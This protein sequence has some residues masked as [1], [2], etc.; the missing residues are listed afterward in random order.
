MRFLFVLLLFLTQFSFAQNTGTIDSTLL[1][2]AAWHKTQAVY[3]VFAEEDIPSRYDSIIYH[4][5]K[6]LILDT[7]VYGANHEEVAKTYFNMG[8]FGYMA[9]NDFYHAQ[10]CFSKAA[11]IREQAESLDSTTLNNLFI[12]YDYLAISLREIGDYP[13]SLATIEKALSLPQADHH[14]ILI[15]KAL[16][17]FEQSSKN[18]N[19]SI[20]I[21]QEA[22]LHYSN[23]Q[24]EYL[25]G[26]CQ[27]NLA[28][29]YDLNGEKE[30]AI[31][32]YQKSTGILK[33]YL[34]DDELV[35]NYINIGAAY[36][37][38]GQYQQGRKY[39]DS[40]L[41]INKKTH[42]AKLNSDRSFI[43]DNIGDIYKYQ[44]EYETAIEHY[45]LALN[46]RFPNY[47]FANK[48]D[49]IPWS[50][51]MTILGAKKEALA[52]IVSKAEC[53]FAIGKERKNTDIQRT[54]LFAFDF[55][56]GVI[57]SLRNDLQ[58]EG[59]KLHWIQE[60]RDRYWKAVDM[61]LK[62]GDHET[63][64]KFIEKSKAVLLFEN[65][66]M[67]QRKTRGEDVNPSL[68]SDRDF[69]ADEFQ[70]YLKQQESTAIEFILAEDKLVALIIDKNG[71]R[72]HRYSD[73]HLK[74][75]AIKRFIQL[76]SRPISSTQEQQELGLLGHSLYL[77]LIAP[78]KLQEDQSLLL[79]PDGIL[80]F[81]PFE[82]LVTDSPEGGFQN[83]NYLLIKH[84]ISY[85]YSAS[86]Q[87]ELAQ[88]KRE[89]PTKN[90]LG[91]A[92]NTF[93]KGLPSLGTE[94]AENI[95]TSMGGTLQKS[96]QASLASFVNE[97][98]DY[99]YIHLSTHASATDKY[100]NEPWIAFNDSLLYLSDF[101]KLP[102]KA[103]LVTLSACET[104]KGDLVEGE[105]VLSLAR[106]FSF[107]GVPQVVT[108]L[109]EVNEKSTSSIM[110]SFYSEIKNGE[111]PSKALREAKLKYLK[112]AELSAASPYYW[113]SLTAIGH[114][115]PST[116][117]PIN[118]WWIIGG[119]A[120]I[121]LSGLFLLSKRKKG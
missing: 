80:Q 64:L 22:E 4:F 33:D 70:D 56:D 30:K 60:T 85:A 68:I 108:T 24:D 55:M 106:G 109:W 38:T 65:L 115:V 23:I 112:S 82:A 101:Y 19:Q 25:Q 72:H 57:F 11:T 111:A 43:Y 42:G 75:P 27:G 74:L 48:Y 29:I 5:Q 44:G 61:A 113:G 67:A 3:Y 84:P 91:I 18:A 99:K 6:K 121:G 36:K 8:E 103:D 86:V 92:P 104:A 87:L 40:A 114:D 95:L 9:I 76:V 46:N 62:L 105:G 31:N 102:L 79:I 7:L 35:P 117:S 12:T 28:L 118:K 20:R 50:D 10:S 21:L 78:L 39:L 69:K 93:P 98:P 53:L 81:V 88:G 1:D 47:K 116:A 77:D 90:W 94:E 110:K 2:K 66:L 120:L 96:K 97:A 34:D 41:E 26:L 49:M 16:T 71:L 89:A 100:R 59:I 37:E 32:Y 45:N 107:S 13:S 119:I 14:S 54:A 83:W 51:T 73:F 52:P 17:L 15:E 63:A 58:G